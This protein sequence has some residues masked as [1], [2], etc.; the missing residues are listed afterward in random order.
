MSST[1]IRVL[2]ADDHAV[3][4]MG[5]VALL[6]SAGDFE[7]I[8]EAT[9]GR[10]A[11][12]W[13]TDHRPDLVV[14]DVRM[15]DLDGIQAAKHLLEKY[16]TTN[17]V[18]LSVSELN[19]EIAQAIRAGAKGYISKRVEPKELISQLRM[20]ASGA[21]IVPEEMHTAIEDAQYLS[22]RELDVLHGMARGQSNKEIAKVLGL[23]IHTIKTYVKSILAKLHVEDRAG[24]VAVGF[25]RGILKL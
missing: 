14:F 7:V 5:L 18:M 13:C 21:S 2:I 20:A 4:R 6:K 1:P 12:E 10:D 24:A 17:L 23:S 9:N 19:D 16:P 11:I 15:P 25:E 3:F 22:P 8:A